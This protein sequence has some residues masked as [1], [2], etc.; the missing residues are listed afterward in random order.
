MM[1]PNFID[2]VEYVKDGQKDPEMEKMLSAHP[3][4]P[5]LLKQARFI[6][7]MLE[8]EAKASDLG[9]L[10]ASFSLDVAGS[11]RVDEVRFMQSLS[12]PEADFDAAE[13]FGTRAP[14]RR[15]RSLDQMI[16]RAGGRG[17][18]L[19]TLMYE[20]VDERDRKSVV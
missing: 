20:D 18:D 1:K 10:A 19:G 2:V 13:T 17:E 11:E 12:M 8:K 3:D 7:K 4:G 5:E 16:D 6:C 14:L 15:R 9:G